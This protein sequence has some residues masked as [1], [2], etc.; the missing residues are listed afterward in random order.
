MK[1]PAKYSYICS[2]KYG[3]SAIRKDAY[4]PWRQVIVPVIEN[5]GSSRL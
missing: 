5:H 1:G 2:I 3:S 4:G